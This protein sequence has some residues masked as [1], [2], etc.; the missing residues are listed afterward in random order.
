M[1]KS[2]GEQE[3]SALVM[4]YKSVEDIPKGVLRRMVAYKYSCERYIAELDW[5]E[6]GAFGDLV[7]QSLLGKISS[8][9]FVSAVHNLLLDSYKMEIQ[10]DI[11]DRRL[12]DFKED[13]EVL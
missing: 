5:A 9:K 10:L 11:I 2:M 7:N 6:S 12:D 13:V 3:Y 8:K 4:P 1:A